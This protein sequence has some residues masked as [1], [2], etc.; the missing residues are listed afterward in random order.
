MVVGQRGRVGKLAS[1]AGAIA[2]ASRGEDVKLAIVPGRMINNAWELP[3]SGRTSG[4]RRRGN[5]TE[6]LCK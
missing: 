2:A 4:Q 5:P 3:V 6:F 1:T